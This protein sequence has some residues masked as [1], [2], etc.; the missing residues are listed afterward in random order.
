MAA[1]NLKAALAV[2]WSF[3]GVRRRRDYD[4]D[5]ARLVKSF[6]IDWIVLAGW[7]HVFS[8]AFIESY[9]QRILNL[10]PALPGTFPGTHAI[11]RAYEAYQRGEITHTGVM[12]H[13]VPDEAVDDGPVVAQSAVAIEPTATLEE[14]EARIH[15]TE[16]GLIVET[17]RKLCTPHG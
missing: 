12:I 3:F 6:G 4:A 1:S 14:L 15:D 8:Q 2:F 9:R 16:H 17:I 10:H 7:M 11:E 13:L 5:L